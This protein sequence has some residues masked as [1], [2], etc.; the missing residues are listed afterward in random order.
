[1][2][3]RSSIV[4]D[5]KKS[6]QFVQFLNSSAKNKQFW[7]EIKEG[8]SVKIDKNELNKLFKQ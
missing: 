1:M 5:P 3:Q 8:A 7:E 6:K 2:I 4:I